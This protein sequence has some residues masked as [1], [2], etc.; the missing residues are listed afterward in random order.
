MPIQDAAGRAHAPTRFC[1]WVRMWV[2]M[3]LRMR[4]RMWL[5]MWLRMCWD[6]DSEHP[7]TYTGAYTHSGNASAGYR[8]QGGTWSGAGWG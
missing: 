3:R 6:V 2:R 4:V 7:T 1:M 5:R 8:G